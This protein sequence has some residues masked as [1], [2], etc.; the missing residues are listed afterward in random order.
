MTRIVSE[1][2]LALGIPGIR[3]LDKASRNLADIAP[4]KVVDMLDG[5]KGWEVES[6]QGARRFTRRSQADAFYESLTAKPTYNY[7]IFDESRIRIV[8]ENGVPVSA[9]ERESALRTRQPEKNV[10]EAEAEGLWDIA[11]A[12]P[13]AEGPLSAAD[14]AKWGKV[15][16]K[17]TALELAGTALNASQRALLNRAERALGQRVMFGDE[18]KGSKGLD[19]FRA[20]WEKGGMRG[21]TDFGGDLFDEPGS[22]VGRFAPGEE[23][24]S[25]FARRHGNLV[26]ETPPGEYSPDHDPITGI[27]TLITGPRIADA[28]AGR[29]S[30]KN[31]ERMERSRA[32]MEGLR[33]G[34]EDWDSLWR[35]SSARPRTVE[36]RRFVRFD[37][38]AEARA[39]QAAAPAGRSI[40]PPSNF[41]RRLMNPAAGGSLRTRQL[42]LFGEGDFGRRTFATH[43]LELFDRATGQ[44]RKSNEPTSSNNLAGDRVRGRVEP[45]GGAGNFL[46]DGGRG[47]RN[48]GGVG[49][50]GGRGDGGRQAGGGGAAGVSAA[51][52]AAGDPELFAFF[53]GAGGTAA[54]DPAAGEQ[55]RGGGLGGGRI[56][57]LAGADTAA[58]PTA[59]RHERRDVV[60]GERGESQ[61]QRDERQRRADADDLGRAPRI[62]DLA[63][64]ERTLPA[65][66]AEHHP[67]I[68][69]AER[70]L[71]AQGKKG[72][73]FTNG[74]GT[75]KT[76]LGLGIIKRFALMGKKNVLIVVPTY[77][78]AVDWQEDAG[79]VQLVPRILEDTQDAGTEGE[80]VVT[81]YANFRTNAALQGRDFDLVVY[82][83]S[84]KIVQS[85]EGNTTEGLKAHWKVTG[86]PGSAEWHAEERLVGPYPERPVDADEKARVEWQGAVEARNREIARR[87][88]EIKALAERLKTQTK[89]L[90]LSATPFA[91]HAN[92]IY[93]DGYLFDSPTE[94]ETGTGY[95]VAQG[96]DAYL[97]SNFGYRM[98]TG[99]L[100]QPEAGVDLDLMERAWADRM[101]QEGAISG[102]QIEVPF[103]YSREFVAVEPG[104]GELLDRGLKVLLGWEDRPANKWRELPQWARDNFSWV[105]QQQLA[106]AIKVGQ[107]LPR[108]RQHLALG[109]KVIL[110]HSY[111]NSQPTNPFAE[112]KQL[113]GKSGA[114]GQEAADFVAK[115]PD[116]ADLDLGHIANPLA[117]LRQEFGDGVVFF[118]GN[119]NTR[120]K[121]AGVAAFNS[122]DSGVNLLVAQADSMKEGVSAHDTTGRHP[123]VVM[124]VSLP[125]KPTDAIQEEGRAYRVGLAS[126][127]IFEYLTLQTDTERF[128]YGSKINQRVRTAEN[129]AM[130]SQSRALEAAFKDGYLNPTT[131]APSETQGLG[132][133]A[134]DRRAHA[135][136]PWETA[137]S[138]YYAR[139]KKTSLTKSAEGQD[140]FATPEPI[141]LKMVEWLGLGPNEDALEPSAGHGAIARFFPNTTNNTFVE[142]ALKLANEL[143]IKVAKGTTEIM[144]F[145]DLHVVNKYDGVAMNPPFGTAG[146]LA[147]AH[148]RKA[149]T[150]LRNG[151]RIVALLP[152]GTARKKFEEWLESEEAKDIYKVAEFGLP[153]ATFERAGTNVRTMIVVLDRV[154]DA[155]RAKDVRQQSRI[156]LEA[157]TVEELFERMR[158]LRVPERTRPALVPATVTAPDLL[159]GLAT[160]AA[161]EAITL[162][163]AVRLAEAAAPASTDHAAIRKTLEAIGDLPWRGLDVLLEHPSVKKLASKKAVREKLL[164]DTLNALPDAAVTRGWTRASPVR[165]RYA[166]A[167]T[168]LPAEVMDRRE[169][170]ETNVRDGKPI[171]ARWPEKLGVPVPEGYV[172]RS[173]GKAYAKAA[174][175]AESAQ[176]ASA[177][178]ASGE[179]YD[180][181]EFNHTRTGARIYVATIKD[182]VERD[183]FLRLRAAAMAQGGTYSSYRGGGAIPGFHFSTEENRQRFVETTSVGGLRARRFATSPLARPGQTNYENDRDNLSTASRENEKARRAD[184]QGLAENPD[185][186]D[187]PNAG[188]DAPGG[189]D[190]EDRPGGSAGSGSASVSGRREQAVERGLARARSRQPGLTYREA[191]AE[192]MAPTPALLAAERDGEIIYSLANLGARITKIVEHPEGSAEMA[193]D[194]LA[195]VLGG[196]NSIGEEPW[197]IADRRVAATKKRYPAHI[198]ANIWH[199]APESVRSALIAMYGPAPA[200]VRPDYYYGA[201]LVRAVC[202][203]VNGEGLTEQFLPWK[204]KEA[205]GFVAALHA[206]DMPTEAQAH[207]MAVRLEAAGK[208]QAGAASGEM[209]HA[210][211]MSDFSK[212]NNAAE[213]E[214]EGRFPA[215][216]IARRLNVPVGFIR[217]HAPHSGEW[218][219]VSKFYNRVPYYD[220]ADVEAWMEGKGDYEVTA[221]EPTGADLLAEYRLRQKALKENAPDMLSGQ[222]IKYLEWSGTRNHP[223]AT[224]RTLENVTIERKPGQ[225]MLTI[226]T[227]AGKTFKKAID[228][229]G[230]MIRDK[231]G[232][233]VAAEIVFKNNRPSGPADLGG[234][235]TRTRDA[236][237]AASG[238]VPGVGRDLSRPLAGDLTPS[239][240]VSELVRENVGL[241]LSI[242]QDFRNVGGDFADVVAEARKALVLAARGFEPGRGPFAAYAG[243]AIRNALRNL[244]AKEKRYA[245]RVSVTLDEPVDDASSEETRL[246][247]L[248]GATGAEVSAPVEAAETR[249]VLDDV[250]AS[251]NPRLAGV[252]RGQAEGRS[253]ADIGAELGLSPEGVRKIAINGAKVVRARLEARGFRGVD[254]DGVLF[255]RRRASDSAQGPGPQT[256]AAPAAGG[257]DDLGANPSGRRV[258]VWVEEIANGVAA[259]E[260]WEVLDVTERF[261]K[262]R[263]PALAF[264]SAAD[265]LERSKNATG[266]KL[267]LALHAAVNYRA[268]IEARLALPVE[269]ALTGR[270]RAE[271]KKAK[272]EWE[273]Y[274]RTKRAQGVPAAQA[275]ALNFSAAGQ[276]LVLATN[277]LF[278]T[279]GGFAQRQGVQVWDD[280]A[281]NGAGGYRLIGNGGEHYFPRVLRDDVQ[282]VIDDP[283][284]HAGLRRKLEGELIA[285]GWSQAQVK[286]YFEGTAPGFLQRNDFFG[287]LEMARNMQLPD[288]FYSY[289]F[290][291]VIGGFVRGYSERLGQIMAFGQKLKRDPASKDLFDE[292]LEEARNAPTREFV[293]NV[294]KQVYRISERSGWNRFTQNVRTLASGL[295][296]ANP[297]T[298]VPR[299]MISGLLANI[300]VVGT[301]NTLKG[302]WKVIS[303]QVNQ[304]TAKQLGTVKANFLDALDWSD[305]EMDTAKWIRAF[306]GT[307][308][309]ASG[310]DAS[311]R[312]VRTVA[313]A[314]AMQFVTDYLHAAQGSKAAEEAEAMLRRLGVDPAAVKAEAGDFK[315]GRASRTAVRALVRAA[316]FGYDVSQ[317]PLWANGPTGRLFYQFGRWGTQRTRTL[318]KHVFEPALFGELVEKNGTRYRVRRLKPL[319]TVLA[320]AVTKSI[321]VGASAVLTGE[322]FAAWARL[323][324]DRDRD[325]EDWDII[326]ERLKDGDEGAVKS[327]MERLL[328][329]VMMG[330]ML[331]ILGQ[332]VDLLKSWV[333]G[334]R[335]KNPIEPPASSIPRS[336]YEVLRSWY[337]R[338]M[339][340]SVEDAWAGA[341]R[342]LWLAVRGTMPGLGAAEDALRGRLGG[343]VAEE[344]DYFETADNRRKLANLRKA[345]ARFARETGIETTT[346]EGRM[347]KRPQSATYDRL[348]NALLLGDTEGAGKVLGEYMNRFGAEHPERAW[349]SVA[350][351]MQARQPIRV[352]SHRSEEVKQ[353]FGEW[354]AAHL[355][356]ERYAEFQALQRT[357][358]DTARSL[359]LMK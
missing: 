263:V 33:A 35:D 12:E 218:H 116:L 121:L 273:R 355:D 322:F 75:G 189:G 331:G 231:N 205:E 146:A 131:A 107:S 303:G 51:G 321:A 237:L 312:F 23:Q 199:A 190:G 227:A 95:N 50:S 304:M 222:T 181:R 226:T 270:S 56:E 53:T 73:L 45:A 348:Q 217:E 163:E 152:E 219:H 58:E 214:A 60:A 342:D 126:N 156:D 211:Y 89:T 82:D 326:F 315:Q 267:G 278:A 341:G 259:S 125:I 240:S 282:K 225:K 306:T 127:A 42:G 140:Y 40:Y 258:P 178:P 87:Q 29:I 347:S 195:A 224:E 90:F 48:R 34:E 208:I 101:M 308:L 151:G 346:F 204:K 145:E 279:S 305:P 265:V 139:A 148:L 354:A 76:F 135:M 317:V 32:A 329:D 179:R 99:K 212:S 169:R 287:Q 254:A 96:F 175:G 67:D 203:V 220:L 153:S 198:R 333:Q 91:Y 350:A 15:H 200:G 292:A 338:G 16:R 81:T 55:L 92:L 243:A 143:R 300:D 138:L 260:P 275:A 291:D 43:G 108:I 158:E 44:P 318:W 21:T 357:Y 124:N 160:E 123:R 327:G 117:L 52:G 256:K 332:P 345:A 343:L 47:G 68:L 28:A 86:H 118:N 307:T 192:E 79:H 294:Q 103:D 216:E 328:N 41:T 356:P 164:I 20:R 27:E 162:A 132:G 26:D 63:D 80:I 10:A 129:L 25:L 359:G 72:M 113:A 334:A 253:L 133:K 232:A 111:V 144:P 330:G 311:E 38:E 166:L 209:Q 9:A 65:L 69:K 340:A 257:L 316:Q 281:N 85:E 244:Y 314:A 159:G 295:L 221:D 255:A 246:E 352:G 271:V 176:P 336:V 351:A 147:L 112:V 37:T 230:F 114:L 105:W 344:I 62:A 150:H 276:A 223:R 290:D 296:L 36:Q 141:G 177:A 93:A 122:D 115:Y 11:Q 234:L 242:A 74:T 174:P 172:L 8:A 196:A 269:Q 210:G 104:L 168:R 349:R 161:K 5:S 98:R 136:G 280:K 17:L 201:E 3:Y 193:E 39:W 250:L 97:A 128:A 130:G 289:R 31:R 171:D 88:D 302:L 1:R 272:A 157:E 249:A 54:G 228:T 182:R 154:N 293:Q 167:G 264:E 283:D 245:D 188:G 185:A 324:F 184:R 247:R 197:H 325:D 236:E 94:Q 71:L 252:L 66:R 134:S 191:T 165:L 298:T 297:F 233:F 268:E 24:G 274:Q 110:F 206:W 277:R 207:F 241:A 18:V 235:R 251:L 183:E 309:K 173:D 120:T 13:L 84:H 229:R 288:A 46:G 187:A 313:T 310:Y 102:R 64:I 238:A 194:W 286:A 213:A 186:L 285:A 109:R 142:P 180:L 49:G 77:K 284:K 7:V 319:A 78:K 14:A 100:N 262:H 320:A 106:E 323:V 4:P 149:V 155:E 30:S 301:V 61:E 59:E 248:P 83:E 70:R 358:E 353:E 339:P 6:P 239:P 215:S 22:T 137:V 119:E 261:R 335:F 2:L 19:A 299:N 170:F 202:Q 57:S 266:R 337:E